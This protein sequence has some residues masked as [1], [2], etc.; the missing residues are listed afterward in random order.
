VSVIE[1]VLTEDERTVHQACEDVLAAWAANDA[2]AFADL[3]APDASLVTVEG[4]YC[5]GREQIR[6]VMTMLYAGVFKGSKVFVEYEDVRLVGDDFAVVVYW[7]GILQGGLKELPPE[8]TR[9]ATTVLSKRDGRWLV[10]AFQNVFITEPVRE[11]V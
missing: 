11:V 3:H 8:E 6:Q 4:L 5:K 10:E 1:D 9:R 7:N 2:D